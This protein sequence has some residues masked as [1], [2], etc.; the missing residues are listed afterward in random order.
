MTMDTHV[1]TSP[2][3]VDR[4]LGAILVAACV[5][6]TVLI[7]G[8]VFSFSVSFQISSIP[9]LGP[10]FSEWTAIITALGAIVGLARG[11]TGAVQLYGHL[12]GTVM[13]QSQSLTIQLRLCVVVVLA[14]TWFIVNW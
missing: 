8:T 7:A 3:L 2:S 1:V 9:D 5:G 14:L 4:L 10:A 13:P 12:R 6:V 11:A